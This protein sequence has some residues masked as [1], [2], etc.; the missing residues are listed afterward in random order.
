M[1]ICIRLLTNIN[2][3]SQIF[4][5]TLSPGLHISHRSGIEFPICLHTQGHI[6]DVKVMQIK[7]QNI[8]CWT[9]VYEYNPVQLQLI[10]KQEYSLLLTVSGNIYHSADLTISFSLQISGSEFH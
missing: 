4:N 6:L 10:T 3:M 9:D 1:N 7:K 8:Q 2:N 5:S